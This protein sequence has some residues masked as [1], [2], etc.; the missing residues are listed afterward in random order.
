MELVKEEKDVKKFKNGG[1]CENAGCEIKKRN[2]ACSGGDLNSDSYR[3]WNNFQNTDTKLRK[4]Y[5]LRSAGGKIPVISKLKK[6]SSARSKAGSQFAEA[7][8]VYPVIVAVSVISVCLMVFFYSCAE[9]AAVMSMDIRAISSETAGTVKR[10]QMSEGVLVGA[11]STNSADDAYSSEN[12]GS[13]NRKSTLSYDIEESRGLLYKKFTASCRAGV[14][15]KMFFN[16]SGMKEFSARRSSVNEA[17]RIWL[18]QTAEEVMGDDEDE[19]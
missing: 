3:G 16:V 11:D 19:S 1:I 8:L 9:T 7:S 12:T 13:V 5:I 2:G 10:T 18:R 17:E 15:I 4:R 6:Q 14:N